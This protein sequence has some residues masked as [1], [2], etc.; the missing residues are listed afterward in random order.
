MTPRILFRVAQ[1]LD[2]LEAKLVQVG[3][4]SLGLFLAGLVLNF[5]FYDGLIAVVLLPLVVALSVFCAGIIRLWCRTE[6]ALA[7]VTFE[8]FW[9]S[10]AL[11]S[12]LF[13]WYASIFMAFAFIF[14]AL[15]FCL[16][17]VHTSLW[18]MTS[19]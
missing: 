13:L 18:I 11:I 1:R 6:S 3:G 17:I 7:E 12:R 14:L 15:V 2:G 5:A 16:S 8:G 9:A 19:R 4:L 10:R